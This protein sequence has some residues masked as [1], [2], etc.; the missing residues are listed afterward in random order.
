MGERERVCACLC[1]CLY[2]LSLLFNEVGVCVCVRICACMRACLY[3]LSLWC[4]VLACV[5]ERERVYECVCVCV[6]E[7]IEV[8]RESRER[9]VQ[10]PHS[11]PQP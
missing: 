9:A 2:M 11:N 5:C 8:K 3:V 1:A 6:K 4:G 7:Y 10:I